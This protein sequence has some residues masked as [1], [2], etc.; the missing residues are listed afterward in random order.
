M[1]DSG[2][3]EDPR[4]ATLQEYLRVVGE[5]LPEV[6]VLE[7][8]HGI[9]YSGKEEGLLFLL[10][11]LEE[12]NREKGVSYEP[13]WKVLNAA[14]YGV[15][16]LR[17]RF[18]LVA[19]REGK[20]FDFPEPT[21]GPEGILS[22]EYAVTWDA[23]ADVEVGEE[24]LEGLKV[25]GKWADLLPSIPEGWNYLWHTEQGGGVPLF[26]WRTRYWNF[27]LKLAK[28]KPAWTITANPGPATGPFHWESRR[29]SPRELAALQT[30]PKGIRF[31]GNY[32][33]V[34]R[35][36]GNAV[37]S[38]LA[39][40]LGRK[41]LSDFFGRKAPAEKPLLYLEAQ[42]PDPRAQSPCGACRRSTR[43][44]SE[45]TGRTQG[46]ARDRGEREE[47]ARSGLA[48]SLADNVAER[49]RAR[50]PSGHQGRGTF[51]TLLEEGLHHPPLLAR[52]E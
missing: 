31:A 51:L 48:G 28:A 41:I 35:Q 24:E 18:F 50:G 6:F 32:R 39:E 9:A 30:F 42:A 22:K 12:I 26:G 36:I 14:D 46:L 49:A 34:Q 23:L 40:V 16:Q 7:N 15:P 45:A 27:L 38:L 52:H 2:R 3:L 44:S 37:P 5:T 4:A 17:Q 21:H 43:A 20:A 29:L 13:Y 11:K 10:L 1:G 47:G 33:D 8:V 19:H 25:R